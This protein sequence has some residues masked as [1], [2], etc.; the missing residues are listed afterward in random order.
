MEPLTAVTTCDGSCGLP[1]DEHDRE[2]P[3]PMD[4]LTGRLIDI[5]NDKLGIGARGETIVNAILAEVADH[6]TLE[7]RHYAP[8]QDAYDRACA[9]LEKR[10]REL[11]EALGTDSEAGWYML[12]GL[13]RL[14]KP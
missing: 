10:R 14:P 13:A 7:I 12:L 8:T 5:V 1:P 9:A 2:H 4:V 3:D 11:A 6:P